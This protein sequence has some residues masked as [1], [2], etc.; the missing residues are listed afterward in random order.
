MLR[1]HDYYFELP[2]YDTYLSVYRRPYL[3]EFLAYLRE[4][5]EPILYTKSVKCYAEKVL[6]RITLSIPQSYLASDKIFPSPPRRVWLTLRRRLH[7]C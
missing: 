4:H 7:M 5:T 6:V 2:E 1:D 3:D